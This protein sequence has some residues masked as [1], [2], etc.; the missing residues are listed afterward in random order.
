MNKLKKKNLYIEINDNIHIIYI[1]LTSKSNGLNFKDEKDNIY[2][3]NIIKKNYIN[4]TQ[5]SK[6]CLY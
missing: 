3:D 1:N 6:I 5:D 4:N 2:V